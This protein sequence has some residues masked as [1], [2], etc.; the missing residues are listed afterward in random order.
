MSSPPAPDYYDVLGVHPSADDE[1]LRT[2]WRRLAARWHPDRAGAGATS[3]FQQLSAAYEVLSDPLA[4]AAYDRRRRGGA[5]ATAAPP[6]STSTP[7][8]P[9]SSAATRPP[10]PAVMLSR[11]CGN[12]NSLLARGAAE[13]ADGDES[14]VITLV[15]RRAEAAQG[16]MATIS[17][18][19]ELW[20]PQCAAQHR[21]S[22]G[23]PRCGGSRTVEDLYS[24][25]LAIPP[26]V[27]AGEFVTPTVG[28]PGMVEPVRFRVRLSAARPPDPPPADLSLPT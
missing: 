24:A 7:P 25:W 2:A 13:Y 22:T 16:G 26:G 23:C 15:L 19:V 10:V 8:S 17:M 28:M 12:L 18:R 11:L 9:K 27:T 14:G 6:R 4:R 5:A 1:E 21:P 20:C 3:T